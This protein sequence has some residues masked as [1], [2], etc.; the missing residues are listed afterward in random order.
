MSVTVALDKGFTEFNPETDRYYIRPQNAYGN[1]NPLTDE[2]RTVILRTTYV[3]ATLHKYE[4]NGRDDSDF[5]AIIWDGEKITQ[6]EYASTRGWTYDNNAIVDATPEVIDAAE[7]WLAN[8]LFERMLI[9]AKYAYSDPTIGKTAKSLMKS[10]SKVNI[11]GIIKWR[12]ANKFRRYYPGGYNKPTSLENQVVGLAVEGHDKLVFIDADKVEVLGEPSIDE[13]EN[14]KF[15]E[16][17]AAQH[18]WIDA[19]Y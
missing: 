16:R 1:Q 7:A 10:G 4:R 9:E 18:R 14:R 12:G 3:G 13:A 17:L 19:V 5:Y 2:Q 8:W 6:T 11:Q 15:A